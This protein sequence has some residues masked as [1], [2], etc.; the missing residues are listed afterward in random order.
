MKYEEEFIA[1]LYTQ[2]PIGND[3]LLIRLMEDGE[4]YGWF[5]EEMGLEDDE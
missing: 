3:D 2:Y 1:W 4:N 5:L